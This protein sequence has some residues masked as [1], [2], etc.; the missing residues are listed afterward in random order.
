[1]AED[2]DL[3]VSDADRDRVVECLRCHLVE[4]RLTVSEFQ[5]RMDQAYGARTEG[6]LRSLLVDLPLLGEA[7]QRQRTIP[8]WRER[9]PGRGARRSSVGFRLH[10][11]LWVVLSIFWIVIWAVT[12]RQAGFG[13]ILPIAGVGLSVGIHGAIRKAFSGSCD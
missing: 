3:R 2:C 10:W 7:S 8:I 6:N 13:P 5:D 4:G 12:F 1:M 9:Q 11:Y